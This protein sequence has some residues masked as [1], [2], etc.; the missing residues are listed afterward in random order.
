M[1][2]QQ[3]LSLPRWIRSWTTTV[4]ALA[5]VVLALTWGRSVPTPVVTVVALVL[6]GAVLAAVHHAEG[7]AARPGEPPGS[8]VLAVAVTGIEVG[9]IVTLMLSGKG[10]T[11]TLARDTLLLAFM[12]TFYGI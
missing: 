8:L 11:S 10:D 9:L 7:V 3:R 4:P 2:S 6:A 12:I 1:V 5:V